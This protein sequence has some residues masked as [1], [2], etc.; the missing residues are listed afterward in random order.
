[1]RF[2]QEKVSTNLRALTL[3]EVMISLGVIGLGLLAGVELMSRIVDT[4]N[5]QTTASRWESKLLTARERIEGIST[6][7]LQTQ[8]ANGGVL[9]YSDLG[10]SVKTSTEATPYPTASMALTLEIKDG[11]GQTITSAPMLKRFN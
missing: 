8:L 1:M 9:D 3:L 7:T 4:Q 2:L 5:T 10:V 6:N 11:S